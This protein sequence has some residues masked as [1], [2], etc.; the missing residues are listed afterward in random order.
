MTALELGIFPVG[1]RDPVWFKTYTSENINCAWTNSDWLCLYFKFLICY[2]CSAGDKTRKVSSPGWPDGPILGS[3]VVLSF[4]RV[5]NP[6]TV[7]F[8]AS[9][10]MTFS[11]TV[12]WNSKHR[13][14]SRLERVLLHKFEIC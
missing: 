3:T 7:L 9:T 11:K 1:Y 2:Q 14:G 4:N 5:L 6:S 13:R 10:Y 8:Y 12:I